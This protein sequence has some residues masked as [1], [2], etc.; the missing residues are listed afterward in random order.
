MRDAWCVFERSNH[1]SNTH[2]A[3]IRTPEA[4]NS[5][6]I[7]KNYVFLQLF[8]QQ[9][10][11]KMQQNFVPDNVLDQL[12]NLVRQNPAIFYPSRKDHKDAVKS[13]N[14][15]NSIADILQCKDSNT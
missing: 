7:L 2:H 6:G 4:R 8:F 5:R 14:I 9:I 10:Y 15:S 11:H 1:R 12:V 3:A 13:T